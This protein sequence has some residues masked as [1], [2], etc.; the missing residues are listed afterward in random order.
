MGQILQ[1]NYVAEDQDVIKIRHGALFV[2]LDQ[3]SNARQVFH[4]P[5][6]K[7]RITLSFQKSA[8]RLPT[9]RQKPDIMLEI[10]KNN[11]PYSYHYIFDAK[12]RIDF[13]SSSSTQKSNGPGPLDDDINT[14]HRYR[15]AHVMK[16]HG[17]S[18]ERYAFGAYVL[19]PW[20]DEH[21]YQNHPFYKS[22]NEVNIGGLPF[23]PNSITLVE[24]FIERLIESNPEDLQEEGILPRGAF[25]HWQSSLDEKVLIG[26]VND[27][28]QYFRFK[29]NGSFQMSSS[30]LKEGWQEA[31]YIALYVT[32]E[33][34]T[35]TKAENGILFYGKVTNVEIKEKSSTISFTVDYWRTLK[36]VI[37][38]V[39]YGVQSHTITTLNMLTQAKEVPELFM[40]S[41]EEIKL[42]R[43]LRRL[44][45]KV[46]TNLDDRTLDYAKKVQAYQI[47]HVEVALD[48]SNNRIEVLQHGEILESVTLEDLTKRPSY[49]FKVIRQSVFLE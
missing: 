39:G 5:Q 17:K 41:A 29:Q 22:I 20:H 21:T 36:E 25:S 2:D 16:Y 46:K 44:T 32:N 19:F 18:C 37:R 15:D 27:A 34:S 49:V 9:V 13:G 43:M 4:H 28:E 11:V 38:P 23:L 24:R 10:E 42:W 14:M 7:E 3:K 48:S 40:K 8:G 47:G 26:T 33:V 1:R 45:S 12:Y 6:T 35:S 30:A 31:K